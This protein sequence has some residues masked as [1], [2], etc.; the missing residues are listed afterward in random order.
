MTHQAGHNRI[1]IDDHQGG[2]V[3]R[4][5]QHIV[6]LGIVVGDPEGE[7]P[8]P[9]QICQS[10]GLILNGEQKRDFL[11]NLRCPSGSVLLHG[12]NKLF[13][14]LPGVVEVRNGFRQLRDIKIRQICLELTKRNTCIVEDHRV[15]HGVICNGGDVV[16][17]PP[18]VVAVDDIGLPVGGV[19]EMQGKLTRFFGT[20]MLRDLVDVVHQRHRVAECIGID[21]LH[22]KR[23]GFAV[24][25]TEV[26]LIG[27]V[28]IAHLNGLIAQ[29]FV[30][31]SEKAADLFQFLIQIHKR[32]ILSSGRRSR[33]PSANP[34]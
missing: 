14:T 22:Q 21:I 27:A 6:D 28:H 13:I 9:V 29:I 31:D 30:I 3:H 2:I 1:Q 23:L 34:S 12:C 32:K 8:L 24:G 26:H 15:L 16:G 10:A 4:V 19:V 11:L 33:C 25:Q 17:H 20:D 7:L 5:E 18:E